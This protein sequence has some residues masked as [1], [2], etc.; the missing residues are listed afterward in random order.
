MLLHDASDVPLDVVRIAGMLPSGA[1]VGAAKIAAYIATLA[2]WAYWRLYY[3]P[4][5]VL[6]SVAVDSKSMLS[7]QKGTHTHNKSPL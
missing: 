5:H 7:S 6:Y 2:S 3:F 1:L 4:F